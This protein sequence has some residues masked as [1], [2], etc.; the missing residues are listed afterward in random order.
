MVILGVAIIRRIFFIKFFVR[1]GII[2]VGFIFI[3]IFVIF[4]KILIVLDFFGVLLIFLDGLEER[5]EYSFE[6]LFVG[7]GF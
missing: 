2:G 3:K 1:R 6:L 4:V 7:E 5:G